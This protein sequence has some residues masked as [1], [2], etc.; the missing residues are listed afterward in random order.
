LRDCDEIASKYPDQSALH[1]V[2]PKE[3]E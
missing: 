1:P 3:L 2:H